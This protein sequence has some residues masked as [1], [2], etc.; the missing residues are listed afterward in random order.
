MIRRGRGDSR[1]RKSGMSEGGGDGLMFGNMMN[2]GI[3][4][5][6][7]VSENMKRDEGLRRV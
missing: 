4:V 1:E 3:V 5:E 7:G 2:W 6:E